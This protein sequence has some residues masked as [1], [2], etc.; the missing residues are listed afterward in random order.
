MF[1]SSA[2]L[3]FCDRRHAMDSFFKASLALYIPWQLRFSFLLI[4]KRDFIFL[5]AS[6][7]LPELY[8]LAVVKRTD[9][10]EVVSSS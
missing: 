4:E 7:Y 8:D 6:T 3:L 9:S 2:L 1:Y 5:M 10:F